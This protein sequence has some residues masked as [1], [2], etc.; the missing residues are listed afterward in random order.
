MNRDTNIFSKPI[1][2]I[3]PI[4]TWYVRWVFVTM[5]IN[6][7]NLLPSGF[8]NVFQRPH[9]PIIIRTWKMPYCRR[10][11]LPT[12]TTIDCLVQCINALIITLGGKGLIFQNDLQLLTDWNEDLGTWSGK[13][14]KSIFECQTAKPSI[15]DTLLVKYYFMIFLKRFL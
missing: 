10:A 8:S 11:W 1:E 9:G 12:G 2:V 7:P 5:I 6:W 3:H 13:Q 15:I 14:L 4:L